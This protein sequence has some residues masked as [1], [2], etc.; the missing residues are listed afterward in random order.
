MSIFPI[1]RHSLYPA[2]TNYSSVAPRRGN[3][4]SSHVD[5]RLLESG[6][7][8]CAENSV[9]LHGDH[10]AG[11]YQIDDIAAAL[12]AA[13]DI[14]NITGLGPFQFNH[15]MNDLAAKGEIEAKGKRC[16]IIGP[17]NQETTV[18]LHW[19][20]TTLPNELL[21]QHLERFEVE[22]SGM[23][24][25]GNRT[26][27]VKMGPRDQNSLAALPHQVTMYG[28]IVLIEVAGR[29]AIAQR[30]GVEPAVLSDMTV[31]RASRA[32]RP[33]PKECARRKHW[34]TSWI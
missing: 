7:R 22:P 8:E 10:S 34:A 25:M 29:P 14:K 12:S 16:I 21:V 18:K 30:L 6:R 19:V 1:K 28:N 9:F 32:I 33:G 11:L 3:G 20:P 13:T 31:L 23:G 27:V 26:S 5:R 15:H 2:P 24:H 4:G 17:N